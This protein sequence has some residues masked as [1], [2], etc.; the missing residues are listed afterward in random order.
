MFCGKG[1]YDSCVENGLDAQQL[2]ELPA[3]AQPVQPASVPE[4]NRYITGEFGG[5]ESDPHG[6][7]VLY[8]DVQTAWAQPVQPATP[9]PAEGEI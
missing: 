2:H 3:L 9:Q 4:F 1:S 7:L 5:I 6:D 8:K